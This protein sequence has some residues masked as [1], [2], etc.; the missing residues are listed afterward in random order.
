MKALPQQILATVRRR[1]LFA[2]D[3]HLV[4]AFSGGPDSVALAR[5]LLDLNENADLRVRITLAHLN[6]GIRGA[7]SDREEEFCRDFAEAHG[8]PLCV[9]RTEP[10]EWKEGSLEAEAR[11]RRY[12]F[13][14]RYAREAD[15]CA[16]AT[17]H[18]AD[19]VAETVLFRMVRGAGVRGLGAMAPARPLGDDYPGIRLVRPMFSIRR[20]SIL[21]YL[22]RE[23]QVYCRDSSNA[24]TS[25]SRN[26]IRHVLIPMLEKEFPTF[27]VESL[28]ALND[29]AIEATELTEGVLDGMWPNL[30]QRSGP[31]E[32]LL[33]ADALTEAPTA[34]RKAAADR[35]LSILC[36]ERPV[37]ALRAEHYEAFAE[38][39]HQRVGARTDLPGGVFAR[40]EHGLVYV[41]RGK[42][43]PARKTW[44]LEVPGTTRLTEL[45]VVVRAEVLSE[46]ELTP[47]QAAERALDNAV[48]LDLDRIRLP[49]AV[50]LRRPG[51]RFQ[52]LGSGKP[53]KL[54]RFLI[55]RK[56][57]LHRRQRM[58]LVVDADGNI[59]WVVGCEISQAHRLT[60]ETGRVLHLEFHPIEE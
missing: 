12:D 3:A 5:G 29:A 54:K 28:C 16:V 21:R 33:D 7:E 38:L 27:S 46:E 35:A 49:L 41:T 6:H 58:P 13:L 17:G 40:R 37:P 47:E 8:L 22:D 44:T 32:V 48:F 25:Y 1:E 56:V 15:A 26:R 34:V 18:H 42:N 10:A 59:V 50:R 36:H 14:G 19:D 57:P 20:E 60:P 45:R 55:G 4:L 9:E 11:R 24:D 52:P 23:G 51:D 31:E 39:A 43:Q 2:P 53:T 30:C